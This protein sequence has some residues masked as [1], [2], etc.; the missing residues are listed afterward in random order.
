MAKLVFL[1]L[2]VAITVAIVL[3]E[4]KLPARNKRSVKNVETINR[5]KRAPISSSKDL[6]VSILFCNTIFVPFQTTS[7]ENDHRMRRKAVINP[8][9]ILVGFE[10]RNP[11]NHRSQLLFMLSSCWFEIGIF[12]L[13]ENLLFRNKI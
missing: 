7:D 12:I 9:A 3:S 5:Q 8:E 10:D 4:R 1:L 11:P 6:E 2:C 13:P